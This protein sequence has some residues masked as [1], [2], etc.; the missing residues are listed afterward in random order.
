LVTQQSA[1]AISGDAA[2]ANRASNVLEPGYGYVACIYTDADR[3]GNSVSVQIKRIPM[4]SSASALRQAAAFFEGGEPSQPYSRFLV[5]GVGANAL[6]ESIPGVAFVV[7]ATEGGLVSVR[8]SSTFVSAPAL[9]SGVADLAV[10]AAAALE[11]AIG[12]QP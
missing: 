8:A 5:A 6:G 12:N 3:E 7:F 4:G 9:R 2:V 1:A 10:G 11:S